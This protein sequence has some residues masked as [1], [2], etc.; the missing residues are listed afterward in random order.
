MTVAAIFIIG[1]ILLYFVPR[2]YFA[3]K[4][5]RWQKECQ[6]KLEAMNNEISRHPQNTEAI[7][8]KYL[9]NDTGTGK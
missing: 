8:K 9:N 5:T 6:E 1:L 4:N 3:F 2:A 7:S